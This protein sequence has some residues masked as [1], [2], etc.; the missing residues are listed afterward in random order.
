MMSDR[1]GVHARLPVETRHRIRDVQMNPL[2]TQVWDLAGE[3]LT[4]QMMNEAPREITASR[5]TSDNLSALGLIECRNQ[6][7][8]VDLC[9]FFEQVGFEL[10]TD[11]RR[12]PE[13]VLCVRGHTLQPALQDHAHR[14]REVAFREIEIACPLISRVEQSALIPQVTEELDNEERISAG[15]FGKRAHEARRWVGLPETGEQIMHVDVCQR[16]HGHRTG[17]A[18]ADEAIERGLERLWCE[19][20]ARS[21]TDPVQECVESSN[22]DGGTRLLSVTKCD[23]DEDRQARELRCQMVG[24]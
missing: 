13:H 10:P 7:L 6:P 19:P 14:S 24:P 12:D 8:S 4:G 22:A 5:R 9:H 11:H 17:A 18:L 21:T 3:C 20:R 15:V 1:G 16:R 2:P 23:D